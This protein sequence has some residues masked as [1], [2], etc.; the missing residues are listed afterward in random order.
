MPQNGNVIFTVLPFIF[1]ILLFYV[2]IMIPEK[3]RKNKYN[4]MIGALKLNDE[5]LTRG[6]IIGKVVKINDDSI[7]IESGPDRTKLKLQ[8]NGILS[9]IS[10]LAVEKI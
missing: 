10:E 5:V 2:F 9:V 3:K 4:T 6:G 8:K 7:I 1:M